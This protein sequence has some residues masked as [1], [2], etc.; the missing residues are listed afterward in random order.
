MTLARS[1]IALHN[2]AAPAQSTAAPRRPPLST[3]AYL[4][5]VQNTDTLRLLRSAPDPLLVH[6]AHIAALAH[7]AGTCKTDLHRLTPSTISSL[8]LVIPI[9]ALTAMQVLNQAVSEARAVSRA[10][11]NAV[12]RIETNLMGRISSSL[13]PRQ[14]MW[15]CRNGNCHTYPQT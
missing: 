10:G 5:D 7:M 14:T 4:Q 9:S 6:L 3:T 12:L 13:V 2:Q 15:P 1:Q 8:R 11:L